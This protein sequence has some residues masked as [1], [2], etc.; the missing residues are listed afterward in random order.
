MHWVPKWMMLRIVI[1]AVVESNTENPDEV[2][3]TTMMLQMKYGR[4]Y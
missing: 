2:R 3:K 4:D 1:V